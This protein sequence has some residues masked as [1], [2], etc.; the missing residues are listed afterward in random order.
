MNTATIRQKIVGYLNNCAD[1]DKHF[2]VRDNRITELAWIGGKAKWVQWH[3]LT[4]SEGLE[5]LEKLRNRMW[6]KVR[7]LDDFLNESRTP[8]QVVEKVSVGFAE[9]ADQL[10]PIPR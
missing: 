3:Q 6:T 5:M 1:I 8:R 2:E 7:V 4:I 9:L 10:I